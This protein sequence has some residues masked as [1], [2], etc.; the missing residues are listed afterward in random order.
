VLLSFL[1]RPDLKQRNGHLNFAC[2]VQVVKLAEVI[3]EEESFK[4][5]QQNEAKLNQL[6]EWAETDPEVGAIISGMSKEEQLAVFDDLRQ[7]KSAG[8]QLNIL[9]LEQPSNGQS[10]T[11]SRT[12]SMSPASCAALESQEQLQ[13]EPVR[14]ITT[15]VLDV[16]QQ[17][18]MESYLDQ[19]ESKALEEPAAAIG[20]KSAAPAAAVAVV[21][22]MA[23][24]AATISAKQPAPT[25]PVALDVRPINDA[26]DAETTRI[27]ELQRQRALKAVQLAAMSEATNSRSLTDITTPAQKKVICILVNVY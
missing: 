14:K 2:T 25:K 9:H 10:S 11:K 26:L 27:R 1:D 6:Q 17:P 13:V 20:A 8:A 16:H 4:D 23:D 5:E 7:A 15:S 24:A 22:P 3:A 18:E 12:A 19:A 21:V